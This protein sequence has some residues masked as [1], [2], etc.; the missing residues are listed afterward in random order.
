MMDQGDAQGYFESR[1]EH[2]PGREVLWATLCDAVLDDLVPKGGVALE[3]GAA[4]CDLINNLKAD[5][6]IAVDL[7]PGV[8]EHAA[9]GVEAYVS[10]ATDLGFLADRSIDSVFA[11]NLVEHLDVED[12][13]TM[14]G[15]IRRV[16]KEGGRLVLIQPNF[17]ISSKRYFDDYT[18]R[19]I[20][21]D[22]SLSDFLRS[23]GFEVERIQPRFLPLTVK[24]RLPVRSWLIRLYLASPIKPMAGQM[25]VVGRKGAS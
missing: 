17:R 6:R 11:S 21:T 20:W 22:V 18:H 5:R 7:W 19:S 12:V 4:R 15:E 24:S 9:N 1:L 8:E 25:L 16:L 3:L 13:R 10:S 23:E 14:V 2:D